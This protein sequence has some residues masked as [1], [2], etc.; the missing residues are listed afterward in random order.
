[1]EIPPNEL[2][3]DLNVYDRGGDLNDYAVG[4]EEWVILVH[5]LELGYDK[6]L[7]T[8]E[9]IEGIEY[10]LTP[11]ESAQLTLG[12]TPEQG[13]QYDCDTDFFIDPAG[14]LDVYKDIPNGVREFVQQFI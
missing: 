12:L 6:Q 4:S 8:G 14:F 13:G 2:G 3:Y 7:Q 11:N 9:W 5:H 1:M 10:V